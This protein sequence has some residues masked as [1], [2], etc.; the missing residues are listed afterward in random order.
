MP[1]KYSEMSRYNY[2]LNNPV[3]F[4]DPDGNEVEM[5]CDGLKAFVL[6]SVDNTFGADYRNQY[7][8]G[9]T[10]YHN[11]VMSAHGTSITVGTFM[12]ADG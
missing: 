8:N 5:C 11:G 2:A 12:M 3:I 1:E 10:A 7:D 9:S 6:T 4:V